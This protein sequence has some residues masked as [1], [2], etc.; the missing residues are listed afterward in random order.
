MALRTFI[1]LDI[2]QKTIAY[3][4]EIVKSLR[5]SDCQASWT[6]KGNFHLTLKFLGDTNENIVPQISDELANIFG[7][8]PIPFRP[9]QI[10]GFP[11]L[12]N[13]RVLWLGLECEGIDE[14]ARK[15]DDAC[16]KFAFEK[17]DKKFV[18]HL[19][20]GRIKSVHDFSKAV[21]ELP[22]PPKEGCFTRAVFYK[23]QLAPGGSIYTP[24]WTKEQNV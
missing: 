12:K 15:T 22:H 18:P 24:L 1:A 10:G 2:D 23:S 20:L 16:A 8:F 13:P 17:E 19:T 7:A 21:Q 14:I 9:T 5:A 4:D 6:K 11:N 3:L